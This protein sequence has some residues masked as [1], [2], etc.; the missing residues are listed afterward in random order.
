M[1]SGQHH[2]ALGKGGVVGRENVAT[3][4]RTGAKPLRQAYNW[5]RPLMAVAAL[6]VL[7]TVVS[8]AGVILDPTQILGSPAWM[9]PLKFS[10]SILLYA[11]TWAWLIA[12][13]P[14]WRRIAHILGTVIAIALVV[15]QVAIVWAAATGTTSH[16]NVST[17]LHIAVWGI[18]A[19]AITT[20]YMATFVTSIAVFFLRLP[21]PSLTYALRAG[22]I[23]ALIGIG[24]AFL[25]TGPS[26][27]QL[28]TP[29]GIIGAHTV[30]APDGGPGLPLLGWSTTSGDYRVAHFIG[31]HA[32]QVLPLFAIALGALAR[33]IRLF[34]SDD[35]RLRLVI[36]ASI[37]Y[38]A[39]V[40]L[41]TLQAA[42]GEPVTSPSAPFAIAGW[43][44]VVL[45]AASSAAILA[46]SKTRTVHPVS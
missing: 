43:T 6:M 29:T 2:G 9:K 37:A 16:F 44:I 38:L 42:L 18:M 35:A 17:G 14:R 11:I 3:L 27:D 25:M 39:T 7:C 19:T 22:V 24:V 36:A 26:P 33:R 10:L 31:M 5:H 21:T 4:L 12:H 46:G 20:L 45:L 32:L 15:E 23:L 34:R 8:L 40:A 41:L 28:T 13:I 1:T 30:G